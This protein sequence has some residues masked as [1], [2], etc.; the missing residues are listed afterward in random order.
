MQSFHEF[1]HGCPF[2]PVL[3][4]LLP[5]IFKDPVPDSWEFASFTS[6]GVTSPVSSDFP[7]LG[8]SELPFTGWLG[9]PYIWIFRTATFVLQED[10]VCRI[11]SALK[12]FRNRNGFA[13]YVILIRFLPY[14]FFAFIRQD[15]EPR[16]PIFRHSISG[17]LNRLRENVAALPTV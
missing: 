5:R 13:F 9:V 4:A 16:L 1:L 14:V 3:V 8:A 6:S 11:F 12:C 15:P 17:E 10:P 7:L 2:V